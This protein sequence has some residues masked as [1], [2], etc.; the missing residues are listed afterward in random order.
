MAILDVACV[1]MR[2]GKD[3]AANVEAV[4]T[5]IR[6]AA[7]DGARLVATPEMTSLLDRAHGAVLAK[8]VSEEQD[9]AVAAFRGLASE[10][11]ISLLIGSVPVRAAGDR[12]FN[13]SLLIDADGRVAARYDKIHMFDVQ[14]NAGNIYRESDSFAPGERAVLGRLGETT[15]GLT[16][17]YDVRFPHLYREL[18]KAGAS[19]IAVPAAFTRITGEA[20]W[21]VLLRARAIETGA[22]ILA[23]A[24]GGRH[25]DGRETYGHSLVVDP[26]GEVIAEATGAEPGI[27]HARLDLDEV[28]AARA[29]IPALLHDRPYAFGTETGS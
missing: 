20:H 21:H 3:V 12:C 25:E 2:S 28:V 14:L 11:N 7:A 9:K 15:I 19:V 17:C 16:I 5:L 23:P 8:S 13:R 26:W 29:R 1:Q 6:S 10:L 22:F 27:I 24:Q 18:A 4:T